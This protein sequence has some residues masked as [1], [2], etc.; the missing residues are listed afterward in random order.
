MCDSFR[1]TVLYALSP[2][3]LDQDGLTDELRELAAAESAHVLVC[4]EGGRPSLLSR[5]LA[6]VRRDPIVAV[7][8]VTDDDVAVGERITVSVEETALDGV[9]RATDTPQV[10]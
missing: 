9:Y 5:L 8:I 4:R 3:E 7:T 2:A 10:E 6:F 1:G